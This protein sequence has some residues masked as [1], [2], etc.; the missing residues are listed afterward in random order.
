MKIDS[1]FLDNQF[2]NMN[3][4]Q[5]GL[6][7]A[8]DQFLTDNEK[9]Q[10]PPVD[11]ASRFGI[12]PSKLRSVM[13]NVLKLGTKTTGKR[14]A[15]SSVKGYILYCL[16]YDGEGSNNCY[17]ACKETIDPRTGHKWESEIKSTDSK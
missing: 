15:T 5:K 12:E 16:P 3:D 8:I 11:L 14:Y 6:A 17:I 1:T 4:S 9:T 7:L 13:R 10:F 2:S